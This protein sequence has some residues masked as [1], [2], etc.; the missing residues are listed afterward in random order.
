MC[1]MC[2]NAFPSQLHLRW[3]IS[4]SKSSKRIPN[5]ATYPLTSSPINMYIKMPIIFGGYTIYYRP[6]STANLDFWNCFSVSEIP[7]LRQYL[8]LLPLHWLNRDSDWLRPERLRARSSIPGRIK[9]FIFYTSF[10]PALGVHS[11]SY[12]MGT[13][14]SFPGGKATKAW[15]W[16]LTSN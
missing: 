5:S 15:G 12:P 1:F 3:Q 10:S 9:I 16:P 11:A 7:Q 13:G 14:G 6:N 4:R 8:L 2:N